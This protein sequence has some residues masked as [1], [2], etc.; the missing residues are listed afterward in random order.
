MPPVPPGATGID[1]AAEAARL[2]EERLAVAGAPP[3]EPAALAATARRVARRVAA[4]AGELLK[5]ASPA[6]DGAEADGC[7]T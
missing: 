6:P 1:P 3:G 4:L 7:N 5:D 2:A